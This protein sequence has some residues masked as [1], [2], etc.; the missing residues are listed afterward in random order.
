MKRRFYLLIA[1]VLLLLVLPA[2]AFAAQP[3]PPYVSVRDWTLPVMDLDP[4]P[5]AQLSAWGINWKVRR[6]AAVEL[7]YVYC[8]EGV[9]T[10]VVEVTYRIT[11]DDKYP[12]NLDLA[13]KPYY[14]FTAGNCSLQQFIQIRDRTGMAVLS[15]SSV[16]QNVCITEVSP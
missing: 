12:Q 2:V 8:E 13:G 6:A 11:K 1:M 7:G 5:I 4:P 14:M 16:S 10:W 15:T 9:C 3:K